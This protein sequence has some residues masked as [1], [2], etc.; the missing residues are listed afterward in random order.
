MKSKNILILEAGMVG[1]AIEMDF[2]AAYEITSVAIDT[3]AVPVMSNV[4]PG[5]YATQTE[6]ENIPALWEDCP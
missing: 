5:W 4:L 6:V 3:G 1:S 2:A